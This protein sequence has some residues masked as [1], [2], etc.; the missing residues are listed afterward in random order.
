LLILNSEKSIS[1]T[2][3]SCIRNAE[4]TAITFE[5]Q[6]EVIGPP[7]PGKLREQTRVAGLRA[8]DFGWRSQMSC[9]A[10]LQ[11][12]RRFLAAFRRW[13]HTESV[14]APTFE[15]AEIKEKALNE[16]TKPTVACLSTCRVVP[17]ATIT[18]ANCTCLN[19]TG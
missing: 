4:R 15:M 11:L 13:G 16:R 12:R 17:S 9:P 14:G 2:L 19:E 7:E 1:D 3:R 18:A 8:S 5:D 6:R 10:Y